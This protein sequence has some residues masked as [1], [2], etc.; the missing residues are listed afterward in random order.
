[1][2]KSVPLRY[3]GDNKKHAASLKDGVQWFEPVDAKE[4]L[5]SENEDYE[6]LEEEVVEHENHNAGDEPTPVKKARKRR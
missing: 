3:V 6:E 5:A 1:M 4:V 2:A